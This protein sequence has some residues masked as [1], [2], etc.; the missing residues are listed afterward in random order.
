MDEGELIE[1]S[2]ADLIRA[3]EREREKARGLKWPTVVAIVFG[4][5]LLAAG[6]LLFVAAHW[7]TLSPAWRFTLVL[8]MVAVM[9]V[10]GALSATRFS[11]LSMTLHAVGTICLGAGIFLTGQ[12]FNLQEHWPGGFMLW[13]LGAWVAWAFLRDWPQAGL[14]AVLTPACFAGEWSEATQNLGGQRYCSCRRSVAT[15]HYLSD[16][17]TA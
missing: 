15:G 12:I 10:A 8:T 14:V 16:G 6:V 9:H 11:I 2:T 17:D 5:L 4:G 13:A 1:T 7:D 3:Y